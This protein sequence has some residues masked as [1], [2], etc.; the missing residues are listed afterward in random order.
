MTTRIGDWIQ[1]ASG[2]NMYPLDPRADEIEI[3]DIAHALSNMC[4]FNGHVRQFYSVAEHCCHVYDILP[5]PLKLCGLLH[6][7]SEAY[8]C[9]VPRPVKRSAGFALP[10]AKAENALMRV[11][12]HKWC[13]DWPMLQPVVDADNALLM[14]E[15]LQL[16][17]PLHPEWR[18]EGEPVPL[19]YVPC[20]T[21]T[22][23]CS[24]FLKRYAQVTR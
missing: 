8:L 16:M 12:A 3:V 1:T 6:D 5:E 14:T 4:R 17:G 13:F 15:A 2:S 7:A 11:I 18:V 19:L 23:A 22:T 24:E 21:P 9:D 20:W 10:Y